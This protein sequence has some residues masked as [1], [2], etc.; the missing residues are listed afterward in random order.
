[1][2]AGLHRPADPMEPMDTIR[3]SAPLG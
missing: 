2:R 3:I 1:M